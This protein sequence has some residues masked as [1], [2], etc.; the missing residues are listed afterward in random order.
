MTEKSKVK[1][2]YEVKM[3][4][5]YY[6]ISRQFK[7]AVL[8]ILEWNGLKI[9]DKL[10]IGQKLTIFYFEEDITKVKEEAHSSI[11][12]TVKEGETLY[13]IA[14]EYG[15]S[16]QEILDWNDKTNSSI[17]MDEKLIIKR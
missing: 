10:S 9:S 11:L 2:T 8:D 7:V 12:H 17:K 3:G 14:R 13:G 6:A 15:V 5:T 1:K 16:L 4:D